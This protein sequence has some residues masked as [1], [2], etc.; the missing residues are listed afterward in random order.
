MNIRK[1]TISDI[2]SIAKVTVDTWKTA[3]RGIID[4]NYLNNLSY[5]DRE[6][7]WR[8]F[9]FHNSFIYVAEDETQNIIGFA[10][11]GP[12]RALSPTYAGELYAIYICP[13]HQNNGVGSTLFRSII[14][15]LEKSGI[16]SLLLWVLSDSPY[17]KFYERHGGHPI[18]TKLLETEGF[19]NLITAYGWLDITA[20]L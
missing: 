11:A 19:T 1:A 15:E 6:E 4:D 16:T 12:E 8:Q 13:E 3:Y 7:G 10:A 9:P 18:E 5:R 2:P 20:V 17:R 14:K